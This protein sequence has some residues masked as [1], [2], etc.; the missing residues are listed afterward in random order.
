[1]SAFDPPVATD[2][3]ASILPGLL[4]TAAVVALAFLLRENRWLA[5]LSPLILAILIGVAVRNTVGVPAAALPGMQ[6]ALRRLL[7]LG[8]VALGLQLTLGQVLQVGAYGLATIVI[9]LASTYAFTVAAGR[10]LGVEPG[11]SRLIATGTAICGASAVL[12][13]NAV[14]PQK[15]EDIAYAVAAVTIFGTLAMVL[16]PM[17]GA[18]LAPRDYGLWTGASIHEV[19]QVVAAGAQGG[20]EAAAFAT[21]AKL[22]R[23]ALLAPMIL[24]MAAGGGGAGRAPFPWFVLGFLAMVALASSGL[25]PH[26]MTKASVPLTQALL[27]AGLAAMGLQTDLGQMKAKGLRPLLLGA[28]ASIF[29]A[30][31]TLALVLLEATF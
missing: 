13:A 26:E 2:R 30:A 5:V 28:L 1:M 6:F 12:A 21:I 22:T 16:F 4:L 17:L 7:R 24:L 15:D 31:I 20:A 14:K 19:A 27:A 10:W 3:P 25:V 18:S 29:I 9:G 8:I 11:L 23:V